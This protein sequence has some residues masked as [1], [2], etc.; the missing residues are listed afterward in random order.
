MALAAA[1]VIGPP[2]APAQESRP[3]TAPASPD[4][5]KWWREARFGM[6]LC[7]GPCAQLK[8]GWGGWDLVKGVDWKT[9]DAQ[10]KT[11]RPTQYDPAK[12]ARLVRQMGAR[13]VVF[14][15]KHHGGFSMWDTKQTDYNVMN[16]PCGK[17]VLK[18]QC[19]AL[20]AEGIR[21]GVYFSKIDWHRFEF[22][23]VPR[24]APDLAKRIWG[25]TAE[26]GNP[27]W[28]KFLDYYFAQIEE[29]LK[30]YGKVDVFWL[31]GWRRHEKM[32]APERFLK[33]VRASQ[34]EMLLND[35]WGDPARA[36]FLTPE[37]RIP[38][39]DYGRPWESC[40][41]SNGS[42]YYKPGGYRS[43]R[44]LVR[45][46]IECVAKNGNLLLNFALNGQGT[47]DQDALERM[48]GIGEWMAGNGESIYGCGRSPLRSAPWGRATARKGHMYLHLFAERCDPAGPLLIEGV[49]S[50]VLSAKVLATGQAVAVA[51]RQADLV[52][53]LPKEF[54]VDP[55]ASVI[56]LSVEEPVRMA[57][58]FIRQWT[59]LTPL[60][61]HTRRGATYGKVLG[62]EGK[63]DAAAPVKFEGKSYRWREV[64]ASAD[65]YVDLSAVSGER[66]A[67]TFAAVD[68]ISERDVR[69]KLLWGSSD[70]CTLYLNGSEVAR[71]WPD[72]PARPDADRADVSLPTGRSTLVAKVYN[73]GGGPFGFYAWL[74][75]GRR[76]GLEFEPTRSMAFVGASPATWRHAAKAFVIEAETAKLLEGTEVLGHRNHGHS[77]DDAVRMRPVKP[78]ESGGFIASV[79][80]EKELKD[81]CALV[82]YGHVE[83]TEIAIVM[84]GGRAVKVKLPKT[85]G[86]R[87]YR[88]AL[89][90]FGA[91][92]AGKHEFHVYTTRDTGAYHLDAVL[93]AEGTPFGGSLRVPPAPATSPGTP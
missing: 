86:W 83:D 15:A 44:A 66:G 77:G 38:Q 41:T 18:M 78:F 75:G 7:W 73:Y 45:T 19:D 10:A 42:W 40:I 60:P 80:V 55:V 23:G 39:K 30:S 34:P 16:T 74:A 67:V 27:H 25:K 90:R 47:F 12:I 63:L 11:F 22:A 71:T 56:D 13:Y 87:T 32:W 93:V 6:F 68:V 72:N 64:R 84:D 48:K 37:S 46:L 58:D 89:A 88:S 9:Y 26:M 5:S 62:P 53:T 49:E 3:A 92:P 52:L 29:L 1:A 33:I 76:V 91:V 24:D 69:T 85:G 28:P 70:R 57:R 54:K 81:A 35:R 50:K 20:R 8:T 2:P 21:V 31:D 65:G 59:V 82:R 36:D 4:R 17:D 61:G 14:T 79:E 51:R 43:R